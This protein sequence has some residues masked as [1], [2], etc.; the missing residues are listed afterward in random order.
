MTVD[1]TYDIHQDVWNY[2]FRYID[3]TLNPK[4]QLNSVIQGKPSLPK[5]TEHLI[6]DLPN[7]IKCERFESASRI[8]DFLNKN[9]VGSEYLKKSK[10]AIETEWMKY[11]SEYFLKL[12]KYF[13]IEMIRPM[14]GYLT[15]INGFPY[16]ANAGTFFTPIDGD[17]DK[18]IQIVMHETMHIIFR[19]NFEKYMREKGLSDNGIFLITE[20]IAELLDTE[21]KD[22]NPVK[23]DNHSKIK[24][25]TEKLVNEMDKMWRDK[26]SFIDILDRLI[27]ILLMT[28]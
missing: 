13:G 5:I 28:K 14:R 23:N 10:N 26:S 21:F 7:Y 4:H 24:A 18:R 16:N 1:F 2:F 17:I 22:I 3:P 19:D 12:K 8:Y 25:G 9:I 6:N 20:T 15:S 11:D 27:T